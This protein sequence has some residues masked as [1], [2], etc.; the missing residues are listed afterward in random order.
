MNGLHATFSSCAND[1]TESM[2]FISE[3]H[4]KVLYKVKG[5]PLHSSVF[6]P[7]LFKQSS[8]DET[9][10]PWTIGYCRCRGN[11]SAACHKTPPWGVTG[12]KQ[13]QSSSSTPTL[14]KI[15]QRLWESINKAMLTDYTRFISV[16]DVVE[17][18]HLHTWLLIWR[19]AWKSGIK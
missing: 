3:C 15:H 17:K 4:H 8:F 2:S 13:S 5:Y 6:S 11:A 7:F 19:N 12:Q 1:I 14:A 16:L 18:A 10:N 9:P